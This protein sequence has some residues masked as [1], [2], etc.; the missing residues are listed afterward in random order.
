[1]YRSQKVFYNIFLQIKNYGDTK[2]KKINAKN[3]KN[4]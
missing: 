4:K 2:K 3:A 1:M